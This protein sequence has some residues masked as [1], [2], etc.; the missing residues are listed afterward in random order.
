VCKQ[1][2]TRGLENIS[3][4]NWHLREPVVLLVPLPPVDTPEPLLSESVGERL[5]DNDLL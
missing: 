4:H 2:S 3:W 1:G 5:V